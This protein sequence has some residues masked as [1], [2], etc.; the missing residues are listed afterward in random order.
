MDHIELARLGG[1]ALKK[2]YGNGYFKKLRA[3][4]KS[5][6]RTKKKT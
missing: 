5:K 3:L 1:N 2:K 4:R 6:G